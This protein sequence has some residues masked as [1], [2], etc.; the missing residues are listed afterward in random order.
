MT[1][2][3]DVLPDVARAALEAESFPDFESPMLATLVDEAFSD[4]DWIYERKLD[5]VRVLAYRRGGD[6]RLVTRNRKE[7]NDAYPEIAQ[8]LR[9]LAPAS[10][11][12]VIDGEVVAFEGDT[13]SFSRLQARMN[14]QDPEKARA[15]G[16]AVFYYV[17]DLLHLN[18]KD[19]TGLE[20]RHRKA[21]LE[22]AFEFADPIRYTPHRNEEGE[23]FLKEACDRGWEGLIA[24]KGSSRYVHS[25][26]RDWL[27]FKCVNRQ[28][29]VIG[30]W[31]EPHGSRKGFGALLIGYHDDGELVYAGKVGTG[32][33]DETLED[34]SSRLASIE[35]KTPPFDRGAPPAKEVHWATPRLVCEVGFTEWTGDGKLRHPRFVGLRTD[36]NP[37]DVVREL[38]A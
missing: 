20:L 30:G 13:T 14:L 11:D 21:L 2:P 38:P 1:R 6:V 12:F 32:Y 33:D 25:R 35:R 7:R 26:S 31:T 34:L 15:T 5:G 9:D 10:H 29:F 16:V 8:A 17:F 24:K 22:S 19:V 23:S 27:K 18:G 37:E 3:F 4:P 28:E 36:K